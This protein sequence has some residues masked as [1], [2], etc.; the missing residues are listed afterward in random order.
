MH[1]II[2]PGSRVI[3]EMEQ[4]PIIPEHLA[5]DEILG[6]VRNC[7]GRTVRIEL[8]HGGTVIYGGL[9]K[10][11]NE[12]QLVTINSVADAV[13]QFLYGPSDYGLITAGKFT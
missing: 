11:P 6:E 13:S 8:I 12:A 3:M 10:F 9:D 4:R 7:Y 5:V 1:N 2:F